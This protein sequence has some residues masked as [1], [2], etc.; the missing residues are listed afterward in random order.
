MFQAALSFS[1][2]AELNIILSWSYYSSGFVNLGIQKKTS[3]FFL[4]RNIQNKN[5][6]HC[7]PHWEYAMWLLYQMRTSLPIS[8]SFIIDNFNLLLSTILALNPQGMN[9]IEKEELWTN[10]HLHWHKLQQG[11]VWGSVLAR[12]ASSQSG[13]VEAFTNSVIHK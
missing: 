10:Y 1:T 6:E 7:L 4:V 13:P 3:I 12:Q 5:D 2:V 8:F 11:S 9:Q